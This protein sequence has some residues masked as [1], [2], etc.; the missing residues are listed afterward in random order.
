MARRFKLFRSRANF[1]H[2]WNYV[3]PPDPEEAA[4]VLQKRE[5]INL[6]ISKG[7]EISHFD[8]SLWPMELGPFVDEPLSYERLW[9]EDVAAE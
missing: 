2:Q 5:E 6:L 3:L 8:D 4:I 9:V 7:E 1:L